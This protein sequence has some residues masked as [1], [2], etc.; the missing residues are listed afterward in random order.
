MNRILRTTG[1]L[2]V[3]AVLGAGGA[4][5]AAEISDFDV[6]NRSAR[7][8]IEDGRMELYRVHLDCAAAATQRQLS[9]DE[10]AFCSRTFV[11]LK[12]S[13]LAGVTYERYGS[14]TAS[15]RATANQKGYDAYRAWVHRY[16]TGAK[17]D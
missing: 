6:R 13:F 3:S 15:R 14:M 8:D 2:M 1:C 17:I 10:V 12:L 16:T 7:S 9:G 5:M 4:A 11:E